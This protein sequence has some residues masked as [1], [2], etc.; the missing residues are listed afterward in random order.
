MRKIIMNTLG[1]YIIYSLLVIVYLYV[2]A[3]TSIP[4][5]LQGTNADPTTFMSQAQIDQ[6]HTFATLKNLLYFLSLPF[7]WILYFLLLVIG[8]SKGL[9]KG[10]EKGI[11]NKLIQFPLFLFFF[12]FVATLLGMPIEYIG[13]KLSQSYGLSTQSLHS[14][15]RESVI[16][17][18]VTFALLFIVFG[19]IYWL[20]QKKKKSWWFYTWLLSVPFT[21]FVM[22]IQPVIIDPLYNDFTPIYDEQLEENILNLAKKA[23]IPADHV[24]QVD[25]SKKTNTMNAYVT[26]IGSNA[27]IVLWDTTLQQLGNREILFIMA[28]EMAHY[29]KKH[30]YYGLGL[31]LILSFFGF[32]IVSKVVQQVVKKGSFSLQKQGEFATLPLILL[33]SSIL[34]FG[35][36][37]FTNYISRYEE[38]VSDSYALQLT[39]DKEAATDAFQ[40]L[41]RNSLS[42]VNPPAVVKFFRY[43]HPTM[44][45]RLSY[46]EKWKKKE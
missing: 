27:R 13:Y 17:F 12:L 14:W 35:A 30:I 45:E 41:V 9:Q 38:R 31:S 25:M 7:D 42:E 34:S 10:I 43:S 29:V 22:F 24:Y 40:A 15:I 5:E 44:M 20:M 21:L 18:W 32:A 37:P 16:D 23:D 33:I 39:K 11:K 6:A 36:T 1:I 4:K 26:G 8:F 3:D 28:H 46:I 19:V 2:L